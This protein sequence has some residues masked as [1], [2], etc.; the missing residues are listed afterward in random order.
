MMLRPKTLTAVLGQ[1]ISGGV[2]GA[3]LLN[4][5]GTLLAFAGF[6][7][8][9]ARMT[10]AIASSIWVS[11]ETYGKVAFN[12]DLMTSLTMQCEVCHCSSRGHDLII[13]LYRM[14]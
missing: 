5:E 6:D 7:D 4:K 12:D 11:Y 14:E 1:V 2:Q 8:K 10:A 9:N 13:F 3:L